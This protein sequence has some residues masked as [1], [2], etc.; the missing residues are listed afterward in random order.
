MSSPSSNQSSGFYLA[1]I[2]PI[3]DGTAPLEPTALSI[4]A[5]ERAHL[6][7]TW[8][9]NTIGPDGSFPYFYYPDQNQ[10]DSSKYNEVRHAGATYSLFQASTIF[11]DPTIR[12][13]AEGATT[14]I[15]NSSASVPIGGAA[16][17]YGTL[18]KLGGQ[19]L[20]LVALLERRRATGETDLDDI[21]DALATFLVQMELPDD[22]GRYHQS[23]EATG[24][25]R[26][27]T[28]NSHYYPGEALLATTR[29][30][31]HFPDG[32]WLEMS[33]RAATYLLSRKDGDIIAAGRVPREDHWLTMALAD[34]YRL[35]PDPDYATVAFMQADA[36]IH[37]Q[38][39]ATDPYPWRIGGSFRAPEINFTSTATKAEAM[40]AAWDLANVIDDPSTAARISTGA[41]RT[42]QFLMRVQYTA[43][44]TNQFRQP[45][46]VI[47]AWAQDAATSRI[48]LDFV[49]HN[50]SALMGAYALLTDRPRFIA[51]P[52]PEP[53]TIIEPTLP[54]TLL[55]STQFSGPN[56]WFQHPATRLQVVLQPDLQ[57]T[58]TH[59]EVIRT[60]V[61][62]AHATL[63]EDGRAVALIESVLND[64]DSAL[65]LP[66][67]IRHLT[68]DLQRITGYDVSG[69]AA[70]P[71]SLP[72]LWEIA[73]QCENVEIGHDATTLALELVNAVLSDQPPDQSALAAF[74]QSAS[75]PVAREKRTIT[76]TALAAAARRRGIPVLPVL[77]GHHPLRE[78]GNGAYRQRFMRLASSK[79]SS[80]AAKLAGNKFATSQL[81][82]E[83]GLPT[84]AGTVVHSLDEAIARGQSNSATR[85]SS[86]QS[87]AI[88]VV[89]SARTCSTKP[90]CAMPGPALRRSHETAQHSSNNT[91]PA[92]S[93]VSSLSTAKSFRS[94]NR[95]RPLSPA[96]ATRPSGNW[97]KPKTI[98]VVMVV[99]PCFS[100]PIIS[101]ND[102]LDDMLRP[103]DLT[104]DSVLPAGQT[105]QVKPTGLSSEGSGSLEVIDQIHPDNAEIAV[106]AAA[107][108]GLDIAGLDI[109]TPDIGS[110]MQFDGGAILEVN[111]GSGLEVHMMTGPKPPTR[112]CYRD[113][114][115]ALSAQPTRPC[116]GYCHPALAGIGHNCPDSCSASDLYRKNSRSRHLR[117]SG[118]RR[119]ALP[120]SRIPRCLRC[121]DTL[122]QSSH[123]GRNRR[124]RPRSPPQRRSRFRLL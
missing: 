104:L 103:F 53:V 58:P 14:Y 113:H 70:M 55:D 38:I 117:R 64:A 51:P 6:G 74:L 92:A 72:G 90:G 67:L 84:P 102:R 60:A 36:M 77:T 24:Q 76:A 13:A 97:S 68:I 44:N 43:E 112:C 49:Q 109:V 122:R 85:S 75:E 66:D 45:E 54:I 32:P 94:K 3:L 30:A 39:P 52:E 37:N 73:T 47:G 42:I 100:K 91:S 35:H 28:P 62:D 108:I 118:H 98:T 33:K 59:L 50:I 87:A 21:I 22:P 56:V 71:S 69:S 9:A 116:T 40:N 26:R 8:L 17:L 123:R 111:S 89:V 20:A 114:H 93:T 99:S 5:L 124:G 15:V 95:F 88:S 78:Y 23:Y 31:H 34:L 106:Q 12:A 10:Y 63:P 4:L 46:R 105:I 96:M 16:F 110:P 65:A 81:L 2:P 27:L 18:T 115:H 29:L 7:A 25:E 83:A 79:T 120:W 11:D 41:L 61:A 48:R 80:I 1:P 19:G 107:T 86:N 101:F 57:I 82:R 119:N 121:A